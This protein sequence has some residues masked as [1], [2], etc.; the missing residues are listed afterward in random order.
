M[1]LF[2][3]IVGTLLL[4]CVIILLCNIQT[5]RTC[6]SS[7]QRLVVLMCGILFI[8]GSSFSLVLGISLI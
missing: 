5:I 1:S 3:I 7:V 6:L 4:I 8:V 2:F